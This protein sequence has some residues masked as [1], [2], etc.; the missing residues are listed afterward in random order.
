VVDWYD[1]PERSHAKKRGELSRSS[2]HRLL[3]LAGV[4]ARPLRGPSAERRSFI[5]EHA[6]DLWVGNALHGPLVIA[7]DGRVCKSYLLSQIDDAMRHIVQATSR[8]RR[9]RRPGARAQGGH[10]QVRP[11]H[12]YYVLM[13]T[14]IDG[15]G[16]TVGAEALGALRDGG[17]VGRLR[18]KGG[19]LINEGGDTLTYKAGDKTET[20]VL[21]NGIATARSEDDARSKTGTHATLTR[22]A[23]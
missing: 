19:D 20:L 2:M 1:A 15:A 4:S 3:K 13:R 22:K 18:G 21:P 11:P 16:D 6:G 5:A 23:K 8:S 7:P 17:L 12:A 10:P 14:G 9:A